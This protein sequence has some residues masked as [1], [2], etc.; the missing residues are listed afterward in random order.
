MVLWC[1]NSAYRLIIEGLQVQIAIGKEGNGKNLIKS[2]SL[3]KL[4]L[5]FLVS[6]NLEV[7]FVIQLFIFV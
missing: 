7:E 1:S 5:Y 4:E 2:T 3:E 6:A